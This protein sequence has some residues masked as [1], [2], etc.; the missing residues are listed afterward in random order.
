MK[1]DTGKTT[2]QERFHHLLSVISSERFLKK[3]GLGN[4]VP[5]FIC[6]YPPEESNDMERLQKQLVNKLSQSGIRVLVINLYDLSVEILKQNG[7]WDWYLAE[8]PKIT[9]AELKEDLQ[10]ILDIENVL[11][12]AIAGLMQQAD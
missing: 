5:F 12:P 9:K 10:S 11:T 2:I 7:D 4:E 1:I 8:E 3:Q 6:P